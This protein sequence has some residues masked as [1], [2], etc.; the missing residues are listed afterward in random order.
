MAWSPGQGIPLPASTPIP[1]SS[2]RRWI[3]YDHIAVFAPILVSI[4]LWSF[5]SAPEHAL[6]SV[7]ERGFL[8]LLMLICLRHWRQ[9]RFASSEYTFHRHM[10]LLYVLSFTSFLPLFWFD[11]Q[12]FLVSF[13]ANMFMTYW[14]IY[15]LLYV[16]STPKQDVLKFV[17]VVGIVWALLNIVQQFTYPKVLFFN[18]VDFDS[19]TLFE[20]R[21]G[22]YRYMITGSFYGMVASY[23][24]FN[25]FLVEGKLLFLGLLGVLLA[26]MYCT[27]TR[28]MMAINLF[29]LVVVYA[30]FLWSMGLRTRLTI[31][32]F[33]ILP[34][35][36]IVLFGNALFG[37]LLQQTAEESTKDNIR[38][39]SLHFFLFDYWPHWSNVF[40]GNG[41]PHYFSRKSIFLRH[42]AADYG[43][44]ASDVGIVGILSSRGAF[45]TIECVVATLKGAFTR[46]GAANLYL[47]AAFVSFLAI[48]PINPLFIIFDFVPLFILLCY[49]LER[50]VREERAA[51]R[52]A[53]A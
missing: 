21:A 29:G 50:T 36:A 15:P 9:I 37:K 7:I 31:V 3:R 11:N 6:W 22:I 5:Q 26:G 12:S 25:R 28:Q 13:N 47:P 53:T 2:W 48:L 24:M 52:V 33:A 1:T 32:G 30:M 4:R 18:R 40:L 41:N 35:A 14:L 39:Q 46:T 16:F 23:Y 51:A 49:V 17:A 8:G 34:V 19:D 27:A 38:I 20:N 42:M 43:Y 10:I 44:Y 45:F